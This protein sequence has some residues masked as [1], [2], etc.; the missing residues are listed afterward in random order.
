MTKDIIFMLGI[1]YIEFDNY[2]RVVVVKGDTTPR[3]IK[4]D[5]NGFI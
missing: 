2:G 3:K 4:G 1:D 5:E